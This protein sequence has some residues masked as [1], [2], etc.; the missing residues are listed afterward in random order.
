MSA[1]SMSD[2][3]VVVGS[4]AS[5]VHLAWTALQKGQ[6][7]LMIDVGKT[8]KPPVRPNDDFVSLK[9]NLSD[10]VRHF[11]GSNYEALIL[12]GNDGEYYGFPPEKNHVFEPLSLFQHQSR[13]FSPLVSFAA[14]G[15]AEAWTGGSYPFNDGDLADFPFGYETLGPYYGEVARRIGISGEADDLARFYPVHDGLMPGLK[16]DQHAKT[17]L[18]RYEERRQELNTRYRCFVGRSRSA[19]L[20]KDLG[21]RKACTYSGRCLWGCPHESFYTPSITLEQCRQHPNFEYLSGHYATHFRFDSGHKIKTV[22]VESVANGSRQEVETGTLVLAAGTLCSSLIFLRSVYED[23]GEIVSLKGLM[24]NRQILMPFVNLGLIG[25]PYE[26]QSYQ[27]HQLVIGVEGDTP[28]GYV[29]GLVT[30][31]KT[32]L[33]HPV[34]QSLPFDLGTSVA[35]FRNLHAALGLVNI[36]FSDHRRDE[37]YM[38]IE[39]ASG[40]SAAPRLLIHYEPPAGESERMNQASATYRKVLWKLGCLAPPPMTHVRP[41]GSS[42]HY[43]GTIPMT[44]SGGPFTCTPS[45]QSRA[46]PNLYFADGTTFPSLPS[47]NLTFTL[48]ANA[49][50]V[51]C[52]MLG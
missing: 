40:P 8:R 30:T 38:T 46:F 31:L 50:R 45:C 14:G 21:H 23:S 4:G 5:G 13:G 7:V 51:G 35:V 25:R 49:I 20:S 33:I 39:P 9:T 32:A 16:L 24:D 41:M 44:A 52:Q 37:N 47:K 34:I 43:S 28:A 42:V 15:L 36:N 12:P 18:A 27:Y 11:L 22:V 19:T 3:I 17:L 2:R 1:H 29:H 10:P 26:P 6:R 48:M